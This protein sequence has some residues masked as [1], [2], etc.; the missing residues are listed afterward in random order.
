[1]KKRLLSV[2]LAL[3]LLL[4]AFPYT[5]LAAGTDPLEYSGSEFGFFQSNLSSAFGMYS[6]WDGSSVTLSG[7]KVNITLCP[8]NG[9][10][11]SGIYLNTLNGDGVELDP[12][13]YVAAEKYYERPYGKLTF[14]VSSE[15]CGKAIPVRI[16]K[17]DGGVASKQYY[18][19][20]PSSDKL[21][22]S[23]S[24]SSVEISGQP[25]KTEYM[26]NE[27]FDPTGLG[28]K[29]TLSNGSTATYSY[30]ADPEKTTEFTWSG[31]DSSTPGEKKMIVD[32]HGKTAPITVTVKD[33]PQKITAKAKNLKAGTV[34]LTWDAL[35]GA[36]QYKIYVSTKENEG[37]T[38]AGTVKETTYT[39]T[40]GKVGTTYYFKVVAVN[41]SGEEFARSNAVSKA[42]L[43]GQVKGLT[44]KSTK[45]KQVTVKW[46]KVTGAKKYLVYVSKNGK[47]GWKKVGTVTTNKFT[48]KKGT[49]GKKLY[50]RVCAVSASG[51]KGE[52]STVKKVK[53]K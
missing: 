25:E 17:P 45:A 48:Y 43:P 13:N 22:I 29:V 46:K 32:Y 37:F 36:A 23:V 35:E 42:K 26:L 10:I 24:V 31:F 28:V 9:T 15:L 2:L 3:L 4:G 19:A 34:K 16:V 38:L 40:K 20:I 47:S 33:L 41:E 5:A 11:Y 50:F 12:A 6:L 49:S 53:V 8:K 7:D 14:S 52:F 27:S 39:Y 18:M 21:P 30:T 1:M 51:K 44:V